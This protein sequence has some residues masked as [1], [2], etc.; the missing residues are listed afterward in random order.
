MTAIETIGLTRHYGSLCAVDHLS[1]SVAS[2]ELLAFLGPNG[3]GKTTTI[4]MLTGLLRPTE[5]S[6]LVAGHDILRDPLA[7]KEQVGVVPQRSNLYAEMTVR[8]NLIF[9]CQLYDLPRKSWSLRVDQLLDEFELEDQA[10]EPFASLSGGMKRRLTIAAALV[11]APS[12]LFLDEPTTGLDVRSARNLRATIERLKGEGVTIF[13]TTHLIPEAERLADRVA[14]IVQGSLVTMGKPSELCADCV[15]ELSLQVRFVPISAALVE[16]LA[17]APAVLDVSRT[18]DEVHLVV[19]SVDAAVAQIQRVAH[20][21]GARIERIQTV[22]PSLEDAFVQ[23]T[24]L[25]REIMQINST[26]GGKGR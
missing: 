24:H 1:M 2:G 10:N 26:S 12:I 13:L 19:D 3:A 21:R 15:Q 9:C 25:D 7:V 16:A 5:G 14:I 18:G 23:I 8:Q 4:R 17:G 20:G 11:H 6:A 22:V